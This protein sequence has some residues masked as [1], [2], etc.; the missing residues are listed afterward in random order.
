MTTTCWPCVEARALVRRT[1]AWIRSYN[2]PSL[3]GSDAM[4][5]PFVDGSEAESLFLESLLS[6][7][8][9]IV[10]GTAA[11]S[12]TALLDAAVA[13]YA[14]GRL[15]DLGQKDVLPGSV[16]VQLGVAGAFVS[17]DVEPGFTYQIVYEQ[18]IAD[19]QFPA[20]LFDV[21]DSLRVSYSHEVDSG[22]I[23]LGISG[24]STREGTQQ[25]VPRR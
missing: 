25:P 13:S 7:H 20:G 6:A 10:A 15:Y 1:Y 8:A 14:T 18:G 16:A 12:P 11:D 3:Q 23:H 4:A 22:I 24:R 2:V 21:Y 17:A 5:Y 19:Y 9:R